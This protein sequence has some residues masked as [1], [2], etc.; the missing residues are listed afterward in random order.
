MGFMNCW[1]SS[2]WSWILSSDNMQAYDC[3]DSNSFNVRGYGKE[4]GAL[5]RDDTMEIINTDNGRHFVDSTMFYPFNQTA[6]KK[7]DD[8]EDKVIFFLSRPAS[9][10]YQSLF[11]MFNKYLMS[12]HDYNTILDKFKNDSEVVNRLE[13]YKK[14]SKV[15]TIST[16]EINMCFESEL[17][18]STL[19]SNKT[20]EK[21]NLIRDGSINKLF[22]KELAEL[23]FPSSNSINVLVFT[24]DFIILRDVFLNTQTVDYVYYHDILSEKSLQDFIFRIFDENK[25]EFKPK[26][27]QKVEPTDLNNFYTKSNSLTEEIEFKLSRIIDATSHKFM[28]KINIAGDRI[29]KS[30]F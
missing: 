17:G 27:Y 5:V 20:Q 8:I 19:M 9:Q 15:D 14:Y 6:Y 10:R 18:L 30:E 12:I 22:L 24:L 29:Y 16:Q 11:N 28:K 1:T 25:I 21:F 4:G 7:L 23:K 3:P 26:E 2:A 13:R